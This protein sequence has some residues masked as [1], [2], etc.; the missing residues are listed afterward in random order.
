M[1]VSMIR[2]TGPRLLASSC[3][4]DPVLEAFHVEEAG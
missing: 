2:Q 3:G 1:A 4:L